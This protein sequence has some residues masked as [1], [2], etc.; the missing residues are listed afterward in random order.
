MKT[1]AWKVNRREGCRARSCRRRHRW[2]PNRTQTVAS[3]QTATPSKPA[4]LTFSS[5]TQRHVYLSLLLPNYRVETERGV[6][7]VLPNSWRVEWG[8][9]KWYENVMKWV[10]LS[11]ERWRANA[12]TLIM[13]MTDFVK[14]DS[15]FTRPLIN[16]RGSALWTQRMKQL[17]REHLNKHCVK[18]TQNSKQHKS[19][20]THNHP[21]DISTICSDTDVNK[22]CWY[23]CAFWR[24][25]I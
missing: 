6:V 25:V 17:P 15:V 20:L 3:E 12:E 13:L 11:L 5:I 8:I 2:R 24:Y 22:M 21:W 18:Q 10:R 16:C 19:A 1:M 9:W 14:R 7:Q 23:N 4:F